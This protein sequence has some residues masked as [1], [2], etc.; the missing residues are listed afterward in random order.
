MIQ[1]GG[2]LVIRMLA[3]VQQ[4]T[5]QPVITATVAPDSLIHTDEYDIYARLPAWGYRQRR[6][7]TAAASMP[8]TRTATAS[9]RCTSTP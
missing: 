1:R 5:I 6:S 3:N 7:A 9:A 2:Q 8:A 4:K